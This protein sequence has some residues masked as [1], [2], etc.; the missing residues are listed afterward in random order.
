MKE[1]QMKTRLMEAYLR[2]DWK[3]IV[4]TMAQNPGDK[5][6]IVSMLDSFAENADYEES[7]RRDMKMADRKRDGEFRRNLET[8]N[9]RHSELCDLQLSIQT[10]AEA[11]GNISFSVASLVV[12]LIDV[13]ERRSYALETLRPYGI[14]AHDDALV[15]AAKTL[16]KE[17]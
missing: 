4:E 5:G 8:W 14:Y 15:A 6:D 9:D 3:G 1:N 10:L 2:Q 7:G 11:G 17:G 16:M 12:E 13:T